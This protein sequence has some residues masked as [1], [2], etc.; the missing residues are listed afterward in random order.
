MYSD[1]T[2][3]YLEKLKHKRIDGGNIYDYSKTE[4]IDSKTK[5]IIICPIHGEFK[6][7]PPDHLNGSGCVKCAKSQKLIKSKFLDKI[8]KRREDRG[9]FYSYDMVPETVGSFKSKIS[10]IC[11]I[12]GEFKQL[13]GDHIRGHGCKA[14]AVES[15][16]RTSLEKFGVDWPSKSEQV[17]EK[18]RKTNN[19]RF[20]AACYLASE[21]WN[22]KKSLVLTEMFGT[23]NV[24]SLPEI[25]SKIK[26]TCIKKYGVDHPSKRGEFRYKSK[27]LMRSLNEKMQHSSKEARKFITEYIKK[28][29]YDVSQVAY[30]NPAEGLYE[31]PIWH[32]GKLYLFDLIVFEMGERGNLDKVVEILEYNGPFHFTE[33]EVFEFGD[34]LVKPWDKK[35]SRTVRESYEIDLTKRNLANIYTDNFNVIWSPHPFNRRIYRGN[36]DV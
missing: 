1:K 23:P 7:N 20:S 8:A 27:L 15:V 24:S 6:Q 11:S 18:V 34:K 28:K 5:I 25:R 4:F 2:K 30:S 31:Y 14:C 29:S 36:N 9:T 16:R 3:K 21:D 33:D 26:E 35:S 12:H 17:K 10:I 32:E 22:N 19:E 13:V